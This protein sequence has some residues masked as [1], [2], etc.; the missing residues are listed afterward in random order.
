MGERAMKPTLSVGNHIYL[1]RLLSEQIGCGKQTLMPNVEEALASDRM[2][3]EELGF[4]S[5]RDLL[6][7]L[8]DFVELK[9]FKG[10]RIYAT[11]V[12]Q[13]AWD[14][15]LA[16]PE[17]Q[18]QG[19]SAKSWKRKKADK[20]LKPV[21]PKR[22]RRE[23]SHEPEPNDTTDERMTEP[24]AEGDASTEPVSTADGAVEAIAATDGAAEPVATADTANGSETDGQ[25]TFEPVV[26]TDVDAAS[27][28]EPSDQAAHHVADDA[29][30][31]SDTEREHAPIEEEAPA[32]QPT[33]VDEPEQPAITLTVIYDPENANAGVTTLESTPGIAINATEPITDAATEEDAAAS[34]ET[35][36]TRPAADEAPEAATP[37]TPAPAAAPLRE[38]DLPSDSPCDFALDVYCP[39]DL[40]S[41]LSY[42]LP[43]GADVMGILTEYYHIA[44]LRGT[45]EVGRNRIAFPM[46]YT[47]DGARH[48]VT[49]R[50]KRNTTPG[51][52]VWIIDSAE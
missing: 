45:I 26:D 14:E 18:K 50:L 25:A 8:D 51:G 9:V 20:S 43:Y 34:E 52:A 42:L 29:P 13:P 48:A 30:T 17:K 38:P 22:V 41:E 32:Q 46:G 39:A 12:A 6:E 40:L 31:A 16:A 28:S 23:T 3:A 2:T 4:D 15:A 47:R 5:T 7:A 33:S 49:I 35:A 10:G 44:R 36:Q 37:A 24:I 21:K 19:G 1:Y 11:I 27:A